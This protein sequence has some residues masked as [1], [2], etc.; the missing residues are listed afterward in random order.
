MT[1]IFVIKYLK[2]YFHNFLTFLSDGIKQNPYTTNLNIKIYIRKGSNLVNI[3]YM[4][5]RIIHVKDFY[6]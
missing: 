1:L 5:I 4:D 2:K 3:F 6:I